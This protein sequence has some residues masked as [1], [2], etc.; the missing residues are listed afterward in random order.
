MDRLFQAVRRAAR[1]TGVQG[2]QVARQ[3]TVVLLCGADGDWQG[4]R[5]A[6]DREMGDKDSRVGVGGRCERP[7]AFARSYREAKLAL[8]MNRGGGRD[9]DRV[10]VFDD[11][12][13]LRVLLSIEDTT[14]LEYFVR[15]A[16][17]PVLDYD[18][19]KGSTLVSTLGSF[20]E[21]GGNYDDYFPR[22]FGTP[23][24]SQVPSPPD[25]GT[26]RPRPVRARSPFRPSAGGPGLAVPMGPARSD[27]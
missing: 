17:G 14:A 24:H 22:S 6:I 8:S 19:K 23:Q 25:R 7:S 11:L 2:L 16:L 3:G 9:D 21:H 10:T 26:I 12:G 5:L 18:A 1:D 13:L 27:R 15:A 4:F 20:L